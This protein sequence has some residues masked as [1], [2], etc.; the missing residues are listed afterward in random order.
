MPEDA[1]AEAH[2]RLVAA[3]EHA[4]EAGMT[5]DEM[6]SVIDD[7]FFESTEPYVPGEPKPKKD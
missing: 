4:K 3:A 2:S 6:T 1:W 5:E 7:V